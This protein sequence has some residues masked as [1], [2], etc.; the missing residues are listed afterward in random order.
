CLQ[1]RDRGRGPDRHRRDRDPGARDDRGDDQP[2]GDMK[3]A[4]FSADADIVGRRVRVSW[5][6]QLE[7]GEGLGAAPALRLRRKQRDFEFP[8]P[9][10]N[11]PFLV[12][13]STA[14]PPANA[15][16]VEIDLGEAAEQDVR[17][18]ATADSV[19]R[20]L[21]GGGVEVLRRTRTIRFDAN[22]N[23]IGYREEILD[24]DGR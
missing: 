24:V 11:D 10:A 8:A 12:Y 21:D 23:P 6:V 20:T 4:G 14:F 3:I 2:R 18:V 19:S 16:V 17:T 7:G 5:D 1:R 22:R 13:D 15:N 9:V